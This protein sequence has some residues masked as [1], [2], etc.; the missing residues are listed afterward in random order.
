VFQLLT[1]LFTNCRNW[2]LCPGPKENDSSPLASVVMAVFGVKDIVT[3]TDAL[4]L[5]FRTRHDELKPPLLLMMMG[6]AKRTALESA[7]MPS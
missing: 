3:S 4:A 5:G 7:L 2:L 1:E 6:A